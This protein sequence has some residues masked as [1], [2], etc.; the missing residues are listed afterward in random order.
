[1]LSS[2]NKPDR[3]RRSAFTLVELLVVIAIIGILIGMLLPAVQQVREAARRSSCANNM[4]QLSLALLNYES[5]SMK[6]PFAGGPLGSL[7]SGD[8]GSVHFAIMSFLE[9]SN[10]YDQLIE[11]GPIKERKWRGFAATADNVLAATPQFYL[12]PSRVTC[13]DGYE[14]W[15]KSGQFFSVTNYAANVQGLHHS[16]AGQPGNDMYQTIS[17][18]TDGTSNTVVFAERYNSTLELTTTPNSAAT[19]ARTAFH[20][21]VANDKNPVF[22]WNDNDDP[23]LPVISPPQIR[24]NLTIGDPNRANSLTTQGLHSVMNITRFDGSVQGVTG[25]VDED[26]WFNAILPDDGAVVEQF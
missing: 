11:L 22:A 5:G 7:T 3:L 21:N 4:K 20:G 14:T 13:V 2:L 8:Y 16:D 18:I 10:Q 25:S 17:G 9:A 24:P 1:M 12:C 26:T 23:P 6:F 19:W 15:P